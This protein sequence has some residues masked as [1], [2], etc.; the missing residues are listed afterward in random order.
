VWGLNSVLKRVFGV[1]TRLNLALILGVIPAGTYAGQPAVETLDVSSVLLSRDAMDPELAYGI[2]LA[3]W[4][5]RNVALFRVGHL[6]AKLMDKRHRRS[7]SECAYSNR[8]GSF[9]C[10]EWIDGRGRHCAAAAQ[11]P[12]YAAR[13]DGRRATRS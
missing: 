2:A 13:Q 5:E 10:R 3:I 12:K 9:L 6:R 7:R 8:R 4:H 1:A 11:S